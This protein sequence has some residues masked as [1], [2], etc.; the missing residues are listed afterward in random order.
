MLYK[1]ML[2]ILLCFLIPFLC[3]EVH[4]NNSDGFVQKLNN[5]FDL[6]YDEKFKQSSVVFVVQKQENDFSQDVMKHIHG[7]YKCKIITYEYSTT[8]VL[9]TQFQVNFT[10]M[11]ELQ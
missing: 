10:S 5:I 3:F 11:V 8:C 2:L 9:T 7:S 4:K 1:Q 6:H